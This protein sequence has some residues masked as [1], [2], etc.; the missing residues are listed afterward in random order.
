MVVTAETS[1][2]ERSWLKAGALKNM[3]LMMVTAK[4]FHFERSWLKLV[5][6]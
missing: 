5:A 3:N 4:T 2:E 6:A 1:H